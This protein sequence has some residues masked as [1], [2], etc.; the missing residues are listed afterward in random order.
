MADDSNVLNARIPTGFFEEDAS[1][2]VQA[3]VALKED[4]DEHTTVTDKF[5]ANEYTT[6]YQLFHD[7]KVAGASMIGSHRVGSS[8]YAN[9]DFFYKF[10]TELILREAARAKVKLATTGEEADEETDFER[11]LAEDFDKISSTYSSENGEVIYIVHK[12]DDPVH[13][14]QPDYLHNPLG[15]NQEQEKPPQK[16]QPLFTSLIGKSSVD[17]RPTLL[18]DPYQLL[19]IV[20]QNTQAVRE[21]SSLASLSPSGVLKIPG[22]TVQPTEMMNNFFHPNWYTLAIPT[23]LQY[24]STTT[25]VVGSTSLGGRFTENSTPVKQLDS[26]VK[27]FA[28]SVDL[29]ASIVGEDFKANI[30]L[31]HIGFKEIGEIKRRYLKSKGE[32]PDEDDGEVDEEEEEEE[33]DDDDEDDDI[34]DIIDQDEIETKSE[35]AAVSSEG[36][37]DDVNI[38]VD[39]EVGKIDIDNLIH[40]DPSKVD[41]IE[42]LKQDAPAIKSTATFQ[43]LISKNLLKLNK[44]RQQRYLT[45]SLQP[46]TVEIKLYN[47]TMKLITLFIQLNKVSPSNLSLEFSKRLPVL[48]NEYVG[49]LPGSIINT[50]QVMAHSKNS[51]LPSVRGPYKKKGRM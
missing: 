2:V 45:R 19:Q 37:A 10:A 33:E 43:S 11:Q 4:A 26:Y 32:L 20:P 35:E 3:Y 1:R 28:P 29:R 39:V 7:I 40:W 50:K 22:P 23:W 25:K 49:T 12:I 9:I 47:R 38:D 34:E 14:P 6:F 17:P 42:G 13:I 46:T 16:N 51:R 18:P 8:A 21:L 30:W 24:Q 48:L 5:N 31:E 15:G 44:L 41:L 27:S 36:T